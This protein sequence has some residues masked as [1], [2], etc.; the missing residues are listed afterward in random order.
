MPPRGEKEEEA[1]YPPSGA[2]ALMEYIRSRD[3]H[4]TFRQIALELRKNLGKRK[5]AAIRKANQAH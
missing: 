3:M 1:A 2:H 4:P 5:A